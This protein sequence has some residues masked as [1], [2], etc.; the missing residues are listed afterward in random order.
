[1]GKTV[2][3]FGLLVVAL[4]VG[5]SSAPP[6]NDPLVN[7]TLWV[8][9]SAEYRALAHQA[10]NT[11]RVQLELALED[12]T[13]S[14]ASEQ[15]GEFGDLAPAIVLDV[16]ETV[17]DNSYYEARLAKAGQEYESES[18]KGW[19]NEA[20]ATAVPGALALCQL[21]H[22]K[23]VA[24]F[25]VTNRRAE[26]KDA[27]RKNLAA[28]GFPLR[29]DVETVIPR[30]ESSDKTARRAELCKDY[31]ILL[32][33]G[34]SATDFSGAFVKQPNSRRNDLAHEQR[35]WWGTRWIVLPNPMY[36]DWE[37]NANGGAPD[38]EAR[39]AARRAAL[40]GAP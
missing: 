13:W 35:E 19:C 36:G 32:L 39:T 6:T 5:C 30:T 17:L 10:Y 29:E 18:W 20:R 2:R 25:Y 21:A 33:I 11:A 7:C 26:L 16:D 31:R 24:V 4:A 3:A 15:A 23:G 38:L 37:L 34:D 40:R 12:K 22:E 14:A 1:M 8:Q 28:L 27:T 9:D